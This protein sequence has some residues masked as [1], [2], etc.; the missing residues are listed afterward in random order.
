VPNGW[1]P[2]QPVDKSIINELKVT[3]KTAG[4]ASLQ[5]TLDGIE[6]LPGQSPDPVY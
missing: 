2:H 4:V 6:T 1:R 3:P 5:Q